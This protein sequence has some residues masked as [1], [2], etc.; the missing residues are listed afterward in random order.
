M[1][2]VPFGLR[3]SPYLALR[4]VRQLA[5]DERARY[6][7]AAAGAERDLY[8]DDLVCSCLTEQDAALLSNELIE[9]FRAGANDVFTF[10]VDWQTRE[11]TKRNILSTVAR[12][13]D[14]MGYVAPVILLAKLFIKWLW[15][16]KIDW[17]DTPPAPFIVRWQQFENELPLL[18]DVH[19]PR[20][21]GVNAHCVTSV[22]GFADASER[23]YGGVVYLHVYYPDDNRYWQGE[24]ADCLSR[25]PTPSQLLSRPLRFPGPRSARW[26]PD[27]WSISQFDPSTITDLPESKTTTFINTAVKPDPP[28]L[29]TLA[30]RISSW[31]KLIRIV[32][33]IFRFIKILPRKFEISHLDVAELAVIRA[34]QIVYFSDEIRKIENNKLLA[35]AF[36]KLNPFLHNGILRVGGR[37][38]NTG[39]STVDIPFCS[40]AATTL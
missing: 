19:L 27:E 24:P 16:N 40:R 37:L 17:D 4:T 31:P 28:L 23:A 36:R 12:L 35:P 15:E 3:C 13:W 2:R 21:T 6:P 1:T 25:G 26:P 39:V 9:L 30:L 8:M 20:H 38:E 5:A 14:L 22:L 33:Y 32:I 7:G 11:C 18:R 34:L 29:Y 10:S